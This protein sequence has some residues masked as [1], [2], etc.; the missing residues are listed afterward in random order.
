M[1]KYILL[2]VALASVGAAIGQSLDEWMAPVQRRL[3]SARDAWIKS[4]DP[5]KYDTNGL[6]RAREVTAALHRVEHARLNAFVVAHPDDTMSLA[7][8]SR[9]VLPVP[10]D[11]VATQRLYNGL[12]AGVRGTET[13]RS[14][15]EWIA[16]RVAVSVGGVAPDFSAPDTSGR[17]VHLSDYRGKYVL[18]DFWASWCGPCREENPNVVAAYKRFHARNFEVFSVS[19]DRPGR[20]EDWVKAIRKDG[21]P[22]GHAS[23]LLFW[24][25]PIVKLYA[26]KSIP[27]N[28][29]IDPRGKII[30]TN[31]RGEQLIESLSKFLN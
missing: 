5:Q 31:L 19:L 15:G 8:L 14:L 13:G 11:I 1:K 4:R 29:L 28:F 7:A 16:A 25:S 30:A 20:R 24:N 21:M 12:S 6:A 17:T 3:D 26:I 10:E 22:W 23:D 27:Q 18:L 9:S 2:V